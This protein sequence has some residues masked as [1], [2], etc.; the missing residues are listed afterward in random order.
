MCVDI[1]VTR[2]MKKQMNWQREEQNF[3]IQT[4]TVA[5]TIHAYGWR[6]VES[7]YKYNYI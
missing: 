3:K 7:V 6:C 4:G 2:E 5:V 1:K